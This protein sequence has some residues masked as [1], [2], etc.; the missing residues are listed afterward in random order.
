[1]NQDMGMG[2]DEREN[3]RLAVYVPVPGSVVD[4]EVWEGSGI[5]GS[6]A[7][8]TGK[9]RIDFEGNRE[10]FPEF[11]DRVRRAAERHDWLRDH[12]EGYPT[13]ACAHVDK[14][15][16]I[17]V[18]TYL[19]GSNTL[20]VENADPLAQWLGVDELEPELLENEG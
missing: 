1:M 2:P 9:L 15:Q 3:T 18:G 4:S 20:E 6:P 11:T 13:R 12:R 19:P 14:N 17:R 7:G 5:V 16:V 10:L 8:G